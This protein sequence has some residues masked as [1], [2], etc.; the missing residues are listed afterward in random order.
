MN[1]AV[2]WSKWEVLSQVG[3]CFKY[4]KEDVGGHFWPTTWV[5]AIL[6]QKEGRSTGERG[7]IPSG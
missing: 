6:F 4:K 3:N 1:T 7:Y 5:Y 2:I